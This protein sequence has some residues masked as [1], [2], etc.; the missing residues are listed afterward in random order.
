MLNDIP[1]VMTELAPKRP[2]FV[3]V[4]EI[5]DWPDIPKFVGAENVII[6]ISKMLLSLLNFYYQYIYYHQV[7]L[8]YGG[9]V[10]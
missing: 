9:G 6:S 3:E 8:I 5:M 2:R 7:N 4:I 10:S 1:N